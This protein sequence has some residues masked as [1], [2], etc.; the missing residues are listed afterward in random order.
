MHS[1]AHS[2]W[3]RDVRTSHGLFAGLAKY[4]TIAVTTGRYT[5]SGNIFRTFVSG[6]CSSSFI[7][8]TLS[9]NIFFVFLC[10]SLFLHL[11]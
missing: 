5:E 6:S 10:V 3:A 4:P 2:T 1:N 7:V 9:K 11:C 8:A